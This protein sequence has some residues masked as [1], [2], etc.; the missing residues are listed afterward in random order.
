MVIGEVSIDLKHFSDPVVLERLPSYSSSGNFAYLET[1]ISILPFEDFLASN[2]V[3]GNEKWTFIKTDVEGAADEALTELN[4]FIINRKSIF[5]I[6]NALPDR[7]SNK[8]EPY[9]YKP[10]DYSAS[11]DQLR[12]KRDTSALNSFYLHEDLFP[13]N[14]IS[15]LIKDA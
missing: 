3:L 1:N 15:R 5:M 14:W 13:T 8:S 12:P 2:P 9:G 7:I 10:F 11:F 4:E 6:E